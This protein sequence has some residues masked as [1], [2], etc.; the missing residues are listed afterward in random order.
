MSKE[1]M[2][3]AAL[4][5]E[6]R[7]WLARH[8]FPEVA[9]SLAAF[10]REKVEEERERCAAQAMEWVRCHAANHA[11]TPPGSI[12]LS[13]DQPTIDSLGAAIRSPGGGGK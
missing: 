5:G 10:V 11:Q 4:E 7:E 3:D 9:G 2:T 1:P 13:I 12:W 6:C 8:G